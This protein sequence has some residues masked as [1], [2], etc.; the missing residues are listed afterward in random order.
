MP[1]PPLRLVEGG[2]MPKV[3]NVY[4]SNLFGKEQV[5]GV[6]VV[7]ETTGQARLLERSELRKPDS[8]EVGDTDAYKVNISTDKLF[9]KNETDQSFQEEIP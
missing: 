6:R 9:T 1:I 7:N 4:M 2:S 3:T 8:V 5:K